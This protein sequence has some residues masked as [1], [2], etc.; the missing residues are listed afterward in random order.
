MFLGVMIDFV[1]S[2]VSMHNAYIL[3]YTHACILCIVL[4]ISILC[5]D[6]C[7]AY[8]MYNLYLMGYT[9]IIYIYM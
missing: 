2:C 9:N 7:D 1:I 6:I 4:Y 3:L 5:Y 8:L